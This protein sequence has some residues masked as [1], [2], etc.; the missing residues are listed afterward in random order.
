[1]HY[2]IR[3]PLTEAALLAE[4]RDIAKA[5]NF[6]AIRVETRS[7]MGS[8]HFLIR[9]WQI[10]TSLDDPCEG[11]QILRVLAEELPG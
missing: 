2:T 9:R 4:L 8:I 10:R 6:F 3:V 1:M 11:T 5:L 7:Q